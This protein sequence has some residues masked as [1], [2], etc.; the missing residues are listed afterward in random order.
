[1]LFSFSFSAG[2]EYGNCPTDKLRGTVPACFVNIIPEALITCIYL[3]QTNEN[4]IRA[5]IVI[6]GDKPLQSGYFVLYLL[7]GGRQVTKCPDSPAYCPTL[8]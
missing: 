7:C 5:C 3:T 8:L 4:F 1:M 2:D 6:L